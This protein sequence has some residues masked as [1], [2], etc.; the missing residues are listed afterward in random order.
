MENNGFSEQFSTVRYARIK[1]S[2]TFSVECGV[3]SSG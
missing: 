2:I 1:N 3:A